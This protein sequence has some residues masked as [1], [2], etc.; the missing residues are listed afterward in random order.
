MSVKKFIVHILNSIK[1]GGPDDIM[2]K[3]PEKG[4]SDTVATVLIEKI[5]R[6]IYLITGL[7]F[8]LI[9][10]GAFVYSWSVFILHFQKGFLHAILTLVNDLLLVLI[11]MEVLRTII[12]YLKVQ[13][14]LLEPFLFI[15]IIAATRKMLTAG[16][17]ISIMDITD[18]KIF[19]RY[20]LDLGVNALVVVALGVALFLIGRRKRVE[21]E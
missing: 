1:K 15:G 10:V 12:N 5:D 11:I 13:D 6:F 19:H 21:G 17:E 18:D 7:S 3:W 14:I 20:L 16:A 2:R 4:T 8:L 9:G